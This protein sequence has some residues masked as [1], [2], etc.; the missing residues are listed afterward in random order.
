MKINITKHLFSFAAITVLAFLLTPG[1]STNSYSADKSWL[2]FNDGMT[3]ASKEN[4]I[5]MVDFFTDWCHWCK[6]MDEKTFQ[7]PKVA[8]KLKDNFV[9][10]RLN[11]EDSKKT[12]MFRDQTFN[13]VQFTR[14]MGV[15]GFP[16]LGF[17]DEKGNIITV[18]PGY[19][20]AEKFLN[21]LEYIDQRCYEKKVS[22][23]EFLKTGGCKPQKS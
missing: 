16:S 3:K 7:N 14:A 5:V 15:T 21:V 23:D 20:P 6:V 12:L 13:N 2:N 18:I 1:A 19:V 8:K 22:F 11:A 4:K 17:I 10:V 9:S